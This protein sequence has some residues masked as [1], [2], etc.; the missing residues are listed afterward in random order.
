MRSNLDA[1]RH[2]LAERRRAFGTLFISLVCMGAGQ[3]V[4]YT[5]LPSVARQ[6]RIGPLQVTSI[7]AASAAIWIFSS[8]YWGRRSD[9]SGRKPVMLLGLVA[10]AI[11]FLAFAT[12]MLAGLNRWLPG[13]LIFPLLIAS[14]CIYGGFGSG[15]SAAA[16]AYVAD[17]TSPEERLRGV[18]IISMAFAFG[19]T[20]GPV[21]G[22][23]FALIGLLA[24]FYFISAL[25]AASA[26]A[27][28]FLLPEHAPPP[29]H[30]HAVTTLR[31][32][33]KRM[34]PFAVFGIVL[35]MA[36]S[37]PIQTVGF[38]FMDVLK[39]SSHAT[40]QFTGIG[41][42]LSAL[43]ALFAQFVVVQR[44]GLSA[45]V[46]TS[47]GLIIAAASNVFFV[48]AGHFTLVMLALL[49]SG[50]GFG[51]A[52]PGFTTGASLSV[53]AHEQGAV[54]GI[55]NAAGAAGFVFGPLIGWLYELSPY[56][57][58]VFGAAAMLSLLALQYLSPVL[59]HAGDI[60][61]DAHVIEETAE[62]PMVGD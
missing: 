59:R 36:V 54:A 19:T 37:I 29:L 49:L 32:H 22:S 16:Q 1:A 24:P 7:F 34:L 35:S 31:W 41:L 2:A 15:T 52:R 18:A 27:I 3:S 43:A 12:T 61:P 39:E 51:L 60:L 21:I 4:I 57:P 13:F 23:A 55:L 26:F 48:I 38:F 53:A 42:M 25:A 20:F 6:L 58:Y 46:L 47:A 14:R 28:Y 11:S 44:S 10:F 40:A 5:I 62:T 33:E 17:R 30:P 9:R 56:V 8:A 45:R 50:L